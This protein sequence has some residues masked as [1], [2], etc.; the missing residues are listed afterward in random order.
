MFYLDCEMAALDDNVESLLNEERDSETGT[1]SEQ[2]SFVR[3]ESISTNNVTLSQAIDLLKKPRNLNFSSL[4]QKMNLGNTADSTE[5]HFS[6][7][8]L[9]KV[10]PT[11]RSST[12]AED[13]YFMQIL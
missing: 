7:L 2:V 6:L 5:N 4:I 8:N 11:A 3:K 1:N 10:K 13:D 9:N 12:S